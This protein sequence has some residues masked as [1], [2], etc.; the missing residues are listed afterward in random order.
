MS[1][2]RTTP[3]NFL[4]NNN[5]SFVKK[6]EAFDINVLW[7]TYKKGN[8]IKVEGVVKNNYVYP[9]RHLELTARGVNKNGDLVCSG[10]F[11]FFPEELKP[12]EAK[13]FALTLHCREEVAKVTFFYRHYF[14]GDKDMRELNFG[15]F[16]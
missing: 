15:S 2:A 7:N 8:D 10:N 13:N 3:S 1:C 16:E 4:L 12:Q 6:Y 5:G 9:I 11:D 14:V